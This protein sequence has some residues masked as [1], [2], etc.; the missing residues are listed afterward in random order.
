[1]RIECRQFDHGT[2]ISNEAEQPVGLL[3]RQITAEVG[4]ARSYFV[5]F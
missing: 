3:V 1:M 5:E 2:C 4:S